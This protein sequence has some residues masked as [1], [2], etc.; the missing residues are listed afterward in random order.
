MEGLDSEHS[1]EFIDG[2]DF[3]ILKTLKGNLNAP[4]FTYVDSKDRF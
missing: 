4:I 3:F 2:I 1:E